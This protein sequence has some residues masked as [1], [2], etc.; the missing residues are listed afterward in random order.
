MPECSSAGSIDRWRHRVLRRAR[1]DRVAASRAGGRAGAGVLGDPAGRRHVDAVAGPAH[2]RGAHRLLLLGGQP[3]HRPAG[4]GCEEHGPRALGTAVRRCAEAAEHLPVRATRRLRRIAVPQPRQA[5]PGVPD[6][7]VRPAAHR[8]PRRGAGRRARRD[9]VVA[10]PDPELGVDP[11]DRRLL[12][13]PR[14]RPVT[15]APGVDRACDQ[16]SSPCWPSRGRRR[17]SSSPTSSRTCS[18]I[19]RTRSC[20]WSLSPRGDLLPAGHQ[21]RSLLDADHR[22]S[23]RGCPSSPTASAAEPRCRPWHRCPG[24]PWR[25]TGDSAPTLAR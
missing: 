12:R 1:G 2:R 22:L 25:S 18:R 7:G 4:A 16:S 17:S 24:R 5:R 8:R 20:R 13:D 6:A 11:G 15:A 21:H 3:G 9:H 19:C 14:L 10:G 23:C